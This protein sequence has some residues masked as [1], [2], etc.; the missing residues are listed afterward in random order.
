MESARVPEKWFGCLEGDAS[1]CRNCA[2]GFRKVGDIC[3]VGKKYC[4][5]YDNEDR[6][7]K[8]NNDYSLILGECRHNSLLGCKVEQPD[9][10]CSECFK[11]F[12][13]ENYHCVIPNCKSLNDYGCYSCECGFFIT[14]SRTCQK[15]PN[16][17][18]KTYRGVCVE[19]LPHYKLKGGVCTIEGCLSFSNDLCTACQSDYELADGTCRFKNCYDWKDD[20]CLICNKGF[21]LAGGR[22]VESQGKF[23]C[24]G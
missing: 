24:E 2:N 7:S 17:C 14:D 19:C 18:L 10:T 4:S 16:G 5:K 13:L 12:V 1:S 22:C 21:N 23:V 15:M 6:C 8:C 11:P 3:K 20:T 9:H